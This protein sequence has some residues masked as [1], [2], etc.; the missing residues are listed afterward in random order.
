MYIYGSANDI[1]PVSFGIASLYNT[2]KL[3]VPRGPND[4]TDLAGTTQ[5]PTIPNNNSLLRL[6]F[7]K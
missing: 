5:G 3:N 4:K 6:E 1:I 2:Q 7:I